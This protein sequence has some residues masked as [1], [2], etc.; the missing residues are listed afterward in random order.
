MRENMHSMREKLSIV[1]TSNRALQAEV[2]QLIAMMNEDH[3]MY[4]QA[5]NDLN[6][7]WR[8]YRE[9][10]KM[11]LMTLMEVLLDTKQSLD[12]EIVTYRMLLE[13]LEKR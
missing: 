10:R 11:E 4:E 13:E 2:D 7:T 12:A 3:E 8:G 5:L 6:M 1:E 9:D